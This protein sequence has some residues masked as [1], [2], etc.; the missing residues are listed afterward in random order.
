MKLIGNL[1]KKVEN[2]KTKEEARD[3]I[4]KAGM[5]LDDDELA[6]VSGGNNDD[7]DLYVD[8]W[9]PCDKSATNHHSWNKVGRFGL[10]G[11][12]FE[13]ELCNKKLNMRA[14]APHPDRASS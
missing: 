1:K 6:Q 4:K 2:A 8:Y 10:I 9:S 5:L 13:C 7:S 3:T 11:V 12:E 14:A